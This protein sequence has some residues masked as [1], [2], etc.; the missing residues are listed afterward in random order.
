MNVQAAN[1]KDINV[2][3]AIREAIDVPSI[4]EAAYSG[5]YKQACAMIAPDMLGYLAGRALLSARSRKSQRVFEGS[6][7]R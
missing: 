2:R 3:K 1:L 6:R 5:K 4:L 7:G